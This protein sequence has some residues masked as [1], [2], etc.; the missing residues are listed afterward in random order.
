MAAHDEKHLQIIT[1]FENTSKSREEI[2]RDL[3]VSRSQVSRTIKRFQE[4]GSHATAYGNCGRSPTFSDR[5]IRHIRNISISSPRSSASDVQR[6]L[7]ASGDCSLR[8]VQRAMLSAGCKVMKPYKRP[9]LNAAQ[10]S[11]RLQWARERQ[12]WSLEQWKRVVWSDET[13]IEIGDN[14]PR[15][16]RLV[17]GHPLTS[18]HYNKTMKHP[19]NVMM[20]ACL[21]FFWPRTSTCN[22]GQSEQRAI[23]FRYR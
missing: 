8:T 9:F 17:D 6:Q 21:S 23:Y 13:R 19:T 4:T 5:D 15:F 18:D 1:L 2:A 7:G 14:A 20:W 11:K 10:I 22:R 16:V 12:H 3:G